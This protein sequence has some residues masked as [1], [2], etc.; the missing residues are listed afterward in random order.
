[1]AQLAIKGHAT[2]G[3]EVINLLETLG[4]NRLGYKDTFVG[5]YYFNENN[6]IIASDMPPANSMVYLLEDFEKEY[7]YKVGDEAVLSNS[8]CTITNMWWD[9]IN[10]EVL[11]IVQG[12]GFVV[13]CDVNSLQPYKKQETMEKPKELLIGFTKDNEGDWILNTHK[14]YEIKEVNGKFKLIKKKPVYPKTYKECA[15]ILEIKIKR[16]SN[17]N[18]L[19]EVLTNYELCNEN[20]FNNLHRLKICRDTYWKIAGE[21]MGLDKPWEPDWK[22]LEE[23]KHCIWVDC[24]DIRLHESFRCQHILTFPTEEMRDAFYRNFKDLIKECKELV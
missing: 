18:F 9:D 23:E 4:A 19:S 1:M 20:L 14:D 8:Q 15:N 5:F 16:V 6:E 3:K 22:N 17:L 21:Q 10:N 24:G 13:N 2:R 11:Y 12:K 7:P